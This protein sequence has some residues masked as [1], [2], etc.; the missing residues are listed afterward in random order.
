[1][2]P[3]ACGDITDHNLKCEIVR[4]EDKI[5]QSLTQYSACLSDPGLYSHRD[6]GVDQPVMDGGVDG[7]EVGPP[8]RDKEGQPHW[9]GRGR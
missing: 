6:L 4:G 5:S 2:N 8:T 7:P 3:T 9:G 1:M